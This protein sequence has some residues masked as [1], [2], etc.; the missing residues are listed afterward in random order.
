M[1]YF[2]CC[3]L[4]PESFPVLGV[5]DG[6]MWTSLA[7]ILLLLGA[8]LLLGTIAEQLRQSALLGYI[9]AGTLVGPNLLGWVSNQKDIFD[10]AE[11]GVALLLFAIGLEFSLPR[12][13]RLGRIPLLAGTLQVIFTL[14]AGLTV[15]ALLGFS[16]AESLA[17]GAMIALSSTAC[18]VRMLN[19]RAELDSPHGRTALGILL[20]QDIAVIPLMLIVT[21]LLN[22][23]TPGEVIVQLG[24]SLLLAAVFVAVF[25][26]LFNFVLPRVLELSSLRRNRDFPILLA[27][28]MAAGSAW[29]AHQ[30]GLSPALGAFVAGVLLAISPFATQIRADIQPL[31]TVLVTLF[32]AAVG[33]FAD[34]GWIAGHLGLVLA[35]VAAIVLGK[36]VITFGL[37]Y[38][39]G[40]PWQFAL[41]T[42]LCLAQVGEFSFVLA[43]VARGEPGISSILSE[44]TFRAMIAATIATLILT[45]YLIQLAPGAA[46]LIRRLSQRKPKQ[47]DEQA[48][49]NIIVEDSASKTESDFIII[50]GF[51]PAGQR[52]AGEL[53]QVGLKHI[54]VIDLNHENLQIAKQYGLHAQLGDA[55]QIEVL[56]HAGLYR[57]R[58]VIIT[59][60]SPT[61]GRQI[62]HLV[63]QMAPGTSLYVRCR[64][65]LHHWQL[66]AAGADVIV[67]E[68]E[69]VGERL[70]QQ[71]LESSLYQQLSS[72]SRE[73]EKKRE[74]Q[75]S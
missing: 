5:A 19:D 67:D 27:M 74:Q 16:I 33:M 32:F 13:R 51:G 72:S 3:S 24:L 42:G 63:R 58:L 31:K 54:V 55:T 44:N 34:L 61:I 1:F 47:V 30:L 29:S 26:G 37:A 50:L 68:E 4:L 38:L 17:V 46:D 22:G 71:F 69:H 53:L 11:L 14:L 62:I 25:Y 23:G 65:H 70:A 66:L 21:A 40:Q 18:V 10:L 48:A 28:L 35:V 15:T 52:V 36:L 39:C 57:A 60:P 64:Y 2:P 49:S 45:P 73:P 75:D 20:V 56:E 8:A 12:L 9:A 7:G 59:L 43:T 6:T 41:G